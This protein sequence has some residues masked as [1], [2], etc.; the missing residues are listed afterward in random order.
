MKEDQPL[1][2]DSSF[3]GG[4]GREEKSPAD[5]WSIYSEFHSQ[6]TG[7]LCNRRLFQLSK[8]VR[9]LSLS[10]LPGHRVCFVLEAFSSVFV[11]F[12]C[13]ESLKDPLKN[14]FKDPSL[15]DRGPTWHNLPICRYEQID[16][17]KLLLHPKHK[18]VDLSRCVHMSACS[19]VC[20]HMHAHTFSAR[21]AGW[22]QKTEKYQGDEYYSMWALAMLSL[23]RF[24]KTVSSPGDW[25]N[26]KKTQLCCE[27]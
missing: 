7:Y 6:P 4:R 1:V 3:E 26:L 24:V 10:A 16:R 11:F 14:R 15:E 13:Q 8:T 2:L 12:L 5:E 21:K 17:V 27:K 20:A 22:V 19:C 18:D 9:K 23:V 25:P